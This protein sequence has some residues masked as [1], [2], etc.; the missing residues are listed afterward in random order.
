MQKKCFKL[1]SHTLPALC[2]SYRCSLSKDAN[3]FFDADTGVLEAPVV[4]QI[5]GQ[6]GVILHTAY[7]S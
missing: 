3:G 2:V 5:A 6:V 7:S 4:V 1:C